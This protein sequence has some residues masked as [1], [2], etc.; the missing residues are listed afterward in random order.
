LVGWATA[1]NA[2]NATAN[3][4]TVA[5]ANTNASTSP[6]V[7]ANTN[8]NTGDASKPKEMDDMDKGMESMDRGMDMM[9]ISAIDATRRPRGMISAPLGITSINKLLGEQRSA[10]TDGINAQL[11]GVCTAFLT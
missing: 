9:L 2:N 7:A 6:T 4:N 10:I 8:A 11:T 5:A 3:V 1:N